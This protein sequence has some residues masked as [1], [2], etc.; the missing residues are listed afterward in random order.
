[1]S[2]GRST[3]APPPA[4]GSGSSV[5]DPDLNFRRNSSSRGVKSVH[6]LPPPSATT[7]Y[8]CVFKYGA[9]VFINVPAKTQTQLLNKIKAHCKY[10]IPAGFEHVDGYK[11]VVDSGITDMEAVIS[12]GGEHLTVRNLDLNSVSVISTVMG[13][14]VAL[15]YYYVVVD[16]MLSSFEDL[17]STVEKTGTFSAMEKERLFKIVAENN[18]IFIGM[19]SK[20]GLLERSDTAWNH[21]SYVGAWEGMREEFELKE[22]FENLEFKLNL[23]QHNTRFFIEILHNQ[24]SDKLEWIIIVLIGFESVL[25]IMDMSGVGEKVFGFLNV[26]M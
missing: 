22:R 26:A 10:P 20:L 7:R 6:P 24:K 19:V 12:E 11:V 9:V 15:D 17:N 1:M 2:D 16:N 5:S 25:M 4:A 23:I 3:S 21:S 14:T 8:L 13:Q 18:S